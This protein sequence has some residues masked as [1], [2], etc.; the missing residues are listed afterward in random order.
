[1]C[2]VTYDLYP[3]PCCSDILLDPP[4]LWSMTYFSLI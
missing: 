1:M 3:S 2:D 4:S